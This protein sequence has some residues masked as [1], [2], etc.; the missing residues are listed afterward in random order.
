MEWWEEEILTSSGGGRGSGGGT[1]SG[2][3]CSWT[4]RRQTNNTRQWTVKHMCTHARSHVPVLMAATVGGAPS[5][6][7]GVSPNERRSPGMNHTDR[8]VSVNA[9]L[10]RTTSHECRQRLGGRRRRIPE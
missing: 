7:V 9:H 6:G 1:S 5:L 8:R 2:E 4:R 10:R 3:V